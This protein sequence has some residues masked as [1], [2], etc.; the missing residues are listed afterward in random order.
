M[1]KKQTILKRLENQI[2]DANVCNKLG[3]Q[4]KFV[5]SIFV[6]HG[7]LQNLIIIGIIHILYVLTLCKYLIFR[8]ITYCYKLFTK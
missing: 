5:R 4:D 1:T 8:S 3:I 2:V 6:I 7:I